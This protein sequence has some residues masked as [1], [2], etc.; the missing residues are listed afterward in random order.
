M[1]NS[2]LQ[3]YLWILISGFVFSWMAILSKH[4]G[5]SVSWQVVALARCAIPLV[6]IAAWAKWDGAKLIVLGS[7]VLWMRSLAG[8][9]S[10]VGS[11]YLLASVHETNL[12]LTDIYAVCNI[13][14]IWV[15][16]LSWPMLGRFPSG[17]VWLSIVCS[18]LGVMLIQG[19]ELQT[20]NHAVLLVVAVSIFT[21]LAMLGLNQLKDLDPRTI[22]VHFSAVAL[23]V[24]ILCSFVFAW[25]EP[26]TPVTLLTLAELVGIGVTASVGQFFLTKAFTAGDPARMSVASLSQFAFVAVLDFVLLNPV[27]D[28]H[29]V[30]GIPLILGP[31]VWLMLQRVKTSALVPSDADAEEP[32]PA[33]PERSWAIQAKSAA[34]ADSK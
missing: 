34:S 11:F 13:F 7:R 4:A 16:L 2:T 14:P 22:V 21:A 8:S 23:V 32:P 1:K 33:I 18:I 9:C 28:W 12:Q 27:L 15:A 25:K 26:K 29:K 31:T 30:V 20:G 10:L 5:E 17:I 24:A 19:A 6:L 3:P